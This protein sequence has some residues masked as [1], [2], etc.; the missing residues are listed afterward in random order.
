MRL[1]AHGTAGHT[2]LV[3]MAEKPDPHTFIDKTWGNSQ[4]LGYVISGGIDEIVESNFSYMGF[5]T[6]TH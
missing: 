4:Q 2:V 1:T 6:S 3:Q 5:A